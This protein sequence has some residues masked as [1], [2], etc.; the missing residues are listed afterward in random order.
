MRARVI[1]GAAVAGACAAVS[2]TTQQDFF[3]GDCSG[4]R[5]VY[6]W[7]TG[8][9]VENLGGESSIFYHGTT[10]S[11]GGELEKYDGGT[12]DGTPTSTTTIPAG[13]AFAPGCRAA[14]DPFGS[15][16]YVCSDTP[17][18]LQPSCNCNECS[19]C[20]GC[21]LGCLVLPDIQS[22]W[23]NPTAQGCRTSSG[24]GYDI[25]LGVGS[26]PGALPTPSPPTPAPTPSPPTPAPTPPSSD[27]DDGGYSPSFGIPTWLLGLLGAAIVFVGCRKLCSG[28]GIGPGMEE[29][30]ERHRELQQGLLEQGPSDGDSRILR[31]MF[32][33]LSRV[34]GTS[35]A[36]K[37]SPQNTLP[38]AA[39]EAVAAA[40]TR[41]AG[42]AFCTEDE[43]K[44]EITALGKT[45][46]QVII[47]ARLS[48]VLRAITRNQDVPNVD[49]AEFWL[50]GLIHYVFGIPSTGFFVGQAVTSAASCRGYLVKLG[51][52]RKVTGNT[53]TVET[54]DGN[55]VSCKQQLVEI[56]MQQRKVTKV[57]GWNICLREWG[58]TLEARTGKMQSLR[59]SCSTA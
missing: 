41:A 52:I 27:D 46:S 47:E 24:D 5:L 10:C 3:T 8:Q 54:H 22:G 19:T 4:V 9:C 48:T 44:Q 11:S 14:S 59:F 16:Q 29:A 13:D 23:W 36:V 6:G 51:V 7:T 57:A 26:C 28:S 34:H 21:I 12:C 42:K 45:T 38:P 58:P 17:Q 33:D 1:I 43:I 55:V 40:A 32:Q 50:A 30:M 39:V 35:S 2:Y 53:Y 20:Q 56:L 37:C 15:K 49:V 25:S 31:Q 18:V